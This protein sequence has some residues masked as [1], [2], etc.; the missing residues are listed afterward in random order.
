M[1]RQFRKQY[2][3]IAKKIKMFNFSN[4]IQTKLMMY[5]FPIKYMHIP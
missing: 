5:C 3:Q 2:I 1:A 4:Q